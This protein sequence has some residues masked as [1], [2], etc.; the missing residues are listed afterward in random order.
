MP[1]VFRKT[2]NTLQSSPM[3][4][5]AE[6]AQS[7]QYI[8]LRYDTIR[9]DTIRYDTIRYDTPIFRIQKQFVA[10]KIKIVVI[11]VIVIKRVIN[12]T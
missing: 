9:Y 8:L 7:Q 5:S 10:I 6:D 3:Q 2:D 12:S 11:V 4:C 1:L